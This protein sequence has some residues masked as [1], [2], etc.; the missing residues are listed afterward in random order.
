MSSSLDLFSFPSLAHPPTH[1]LF[2]SNFDGQILC[3]ESPLVSAGPPA[4]VLFITVSS[5]PQAHNVLW[6]SPCYNDQLWLGPWSLCQEGTGG[7]P[8][9]VG[10]PHTS[11]G[12]RQNKARKRYVGGLCG[13]G[14]EGKKRNIYMV[15]IFCLHTK[16]TNK[17]LMCHSFF[18]ARS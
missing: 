3:L 12:M 7:K 1:H 15:S 2:I 8:Q 9:L 13:S 5:L 16:K 11:E 17:F 18:K 6:A 14:V 4:M 10:I